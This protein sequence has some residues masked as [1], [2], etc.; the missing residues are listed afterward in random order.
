MEKCAQKRFD[1][2]DTVRDTQMS[3]FALIETY[4]ANCLELV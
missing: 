1:R 3:A 4:V 2:A